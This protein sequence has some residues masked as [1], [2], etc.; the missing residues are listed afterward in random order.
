M[1]NRRLNAR[2]HQTSTLATGQRRIQ[3][4]DSGF[5][6]Q[7]RNDFAAIA[8]KPMLTSKRTQNSSSTSSASLHASSKRAPQTPALASR[9]VGEPLYVNGAHVKGMA[10]DRMYT[11]PPAGTHTYMTVSGQPVNGPVY[12]SHPIHTEYTTAVQP[13]LMPHHH[14]HPYVVASH[15]AAPVPTTREPASYPMDIDQNNRPSEIERI[16]GTAS[17]RR[18]VVRVEG[19]HYEASA[20]DLQV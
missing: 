17:T 1:R 11:V 14:H 10:M 6:I 19:L 20:D 5:T 15:P 8:K 13:G 2:F 9:P 18:T 12:T 7:I 4:A 3:S 16:R